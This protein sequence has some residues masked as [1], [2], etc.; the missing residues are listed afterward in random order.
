MCAFIYLNVFPV[1]LCIF[2][3]W[4]ANFF[5]HVLNALRNRWFDNCNMW[6]GL[7]LLIIAKSFSRYS[8]NNF[9]T[10]KCQRINS[11][12]FEFEIE[13]ND[14]L[15]FVSCEIMIDSHLWCKLQ[16]RTVIDYRALFQRSYIQW[17]SRLLLISISLSAI[18]RL[19]VSVKPL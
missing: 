15:L 19:P 2:L 6:Y 13:L 17:N 18:S 5:R 4:L 16:P 14:Y 9:S 12:K 8:Y 7:I 3:T 1:V 10:M 11:F